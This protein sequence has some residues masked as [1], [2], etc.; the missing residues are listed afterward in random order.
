MDILIAVI[1]TAVVVG[2]LSLVAGGYLHYRFG[3]KVKAA[4]EAVVGAAVSAVKQ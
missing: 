1:A 2:P 3:A 4:G